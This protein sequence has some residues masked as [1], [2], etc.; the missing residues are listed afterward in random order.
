VVSANPFS[1]SSEQDDNSKISSIGFLYHFLFAIK[2]KDRIF[3]R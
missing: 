2:K 1:F 3:A